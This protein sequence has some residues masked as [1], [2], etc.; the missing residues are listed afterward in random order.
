MPT[1]LSRASAR[2][3]DQGVSFDLCVWDGPMPEDDRAAAREYEAV[4]AELG[5]PR[6]PTAAIREYVEA[7]TERWPED[8]PDSPWA[9]GPLLEEASGRVVYFAIAW[10]AADEVPPVAASIAAELGLVCYDPQ[11]MTLL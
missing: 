4:M 9:A 3:Q 6:T 10:S 11:S 2:G 8:A 5:D 1:T 7:L